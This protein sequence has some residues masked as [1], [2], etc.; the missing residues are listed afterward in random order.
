MERAVQDVNDPDEAYLRI[1]AELAR[2]RINR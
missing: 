2:L 1:S